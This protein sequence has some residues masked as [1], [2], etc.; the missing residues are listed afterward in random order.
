M[1]AREAMSPEAAMTLPS[2]RPRLAS[3]SA[4]EF[5]VKRRGPGPSGPM[6]KSTN[7]VPAGPQRQSHFLRS[8]MLAASSDHSGRVFYSLNMESQWQW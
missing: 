3:F 5:A 2:S 7:S 6:I 1:P 4:S 8:P